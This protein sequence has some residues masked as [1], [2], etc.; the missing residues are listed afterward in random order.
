VI[1]NPPITK[2][3]RNRV[4]RAASHGGKPD[5]GRHIATITLK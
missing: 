1:P 2:A 4:P 5:F 3:R